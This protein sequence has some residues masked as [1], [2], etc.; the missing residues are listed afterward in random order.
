MHQLVGDDPLELLAVSPCS[1]V[2]S[3]WRST[4]APS[5]CDRAGRHEADGIG[6]EAPAAT[7][8]QRMPIGQCQRDGRLPGVQP[9]PGHDST[10]LRQQGLAGRDIVHREVPAAVA[11][12]ATV[13]IGDAPAGE[14]CA[15]GAA[16]TVAE[17]QPLAVRLAVRLAPDVLHVPVLEDLPRR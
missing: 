6:R 4:T 1:T 8:G 7:A 14:R 10:H 9:G 17:G 5:R 11:D 2:I 16:A 13:R 3:T 12:L 15:D